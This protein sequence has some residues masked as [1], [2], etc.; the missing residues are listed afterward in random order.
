MMPAPERPQPAFVPGSTG[1]DLLRRVL[2]VNSERALIERIVSLDHPDLRMTLRDTGPEGTQVAEMDRHTA[3][4]LLWA[5]NDAL[6]TIH[7]ADRRIP[8]APGDTLLLPPNTAWRASSGLILCE[9]AG[10]EAIG[11]EITGPTHGDETFHGYN[12]QT[13]YPSPPGLAIE[14]WKLTAS[15]ALPDSATPYAVM[16]LLDPLALVWSGG[17]DLVG[18]GECRLIQPGTGPITL[19]PNGLGYALIVRR[20]SVDE[21]D[22]FQPPPGCYSD[23][24]NTRP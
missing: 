20:Q 6:A 23:A 13:R 7:V 24:R 12:R 10:P 1:H 3:V 15:L 5:L 17:M 9:V 14:R 2:R 22:A 8:I 16:D 11:A 21:T 19:I 18:R 4:H